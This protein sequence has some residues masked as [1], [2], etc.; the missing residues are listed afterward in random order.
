MITRT[1]LLTETHYFQKKGLQK[2]LFDKQLQNSKL[3]SNSAQTFRLDSQFQIFDNPSAEFH[4][5]GGGQGEG[6]GGGVA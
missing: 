6:G 5:G 2:S 3:F 1:V 4:G